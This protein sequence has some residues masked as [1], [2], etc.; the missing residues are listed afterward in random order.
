MFQMTKKKSAQLD[1]S[2]LKILADFLNFDFKKD[3][4]AKLKGK[5]GGHMLAFLHWPGDEEAKQLQAEIRG[6]LTVIVPPAKTQTPEEAYRLLE[7]LVRKINKMGLNPEWN[8]ESVD[9]EIDGYNDSKTGKFELALHEKSARE[10]TEVYKLLGGGQRVLKLLGS[11]WVVSTRILGPAVKSLRESLYGIIIDALESGELFRLRRCLNCQVF[12]MAED[13]KQKYCTPT[14][15]KAADQ[16][17]AL[18]RVTEWRRQK[19]RKEVAQAK[20]AKKNRA[21]GKFSSFMKVASKSQHTEMEQKRI[22]PIIKR[23]GK[24][25]PLNGWTRF[26][27]WNKTLLSGGTIESI[28]AELRRNDKK[29]FE[30]RN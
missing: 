8:L 6:E 20:E 14:C 13:L 11:N 4:P 28:W 23:L 22:R 21:F 3:D 30:T 25:T 9:Y 17:A 29:I 1:N 7:A 5:D 12:F 16:K 18:K 19:K 26:N 27:T 15:T 24:G 10:K 2:P